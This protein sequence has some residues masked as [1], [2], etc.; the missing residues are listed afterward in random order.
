[1][2]N[3]CNS[4][5]A[6]RVGIT[7]GMIVVIEGTDLPG[8]RCGP[9]PAGEWYENI[10]VGVCRRSAGRFGLVVAPSRPWEVVNVVAGDAPGARWEFDIIVRNGAGGVDFGGP[11]VRGKR[12]DRH[13]GLAWGG[14]LD[15]GIFRLFRGAKLRL[16]DIDSTLLQTASRSGRRLIGRVGLTD[17]KGHPRCATVRPP[18]IVWSAELA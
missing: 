8:Q 11:F 7:V 5:N 4:L 18:A 12:G 10:Y 14:I 1:V 2:P 3:R 9:N 13:I 17:A 15:D 6:R 16:D